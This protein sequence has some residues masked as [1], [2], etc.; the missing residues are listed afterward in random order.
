MANIN[1]G[2]DGITASENSIIVIDKL[3]R[4]PPKNIS[5]SQPVNSSNNVSVIDKIPRTPPKFVSSQPAANNVS[6][7]KSPPNRSRTKSK[8]SPKSQ[9]SKTTRSSSVVS[10][11]RDRSNSLSSTNKRKRPGNSQKD[12]TCGVCEN[13][14]EL[15]DQDSVKCDCC[16]SWYHS[17]CVN[18]SLAELKAISLLRDKVMWYCPGCKLGAENLH[19]A[20]IM[21]N[22]RIGNLEKSVSKIEKSTNNLK[23]QQNALKDDIKTV[24]TKQTEEIT[25]VEEMIETNKGYIDINSSDIQHNSARINAVKS[26]V[27]TLNLKVDNLQQNMLATLQKEIKD[28]VDKKCANPQI[29]SHAEVQL[30]NFKLQADEYVATKLK[31]LSDAK[32]PNADETTDKVISFKAQIDEY[33][34]KKVQEIRDA[35][36]PMLPPANPADNNTSDQNPIQS[37]TYYQRFSTAV[38]GEL[39]ELEE[40]KRRKN[41]L[42]IM[43]LNESRTNAEDLTKIKEL[44]NILKLDKEVIINE[45]IRLGEKRRD[46]K[47]RFIRVTLQELEVRRKI[48]AKATTLREIPSGSDFHQVYIKPNL[49]KQQN[50]HSKNLQEDL[51][52]RRLANPEKTLKISKGKIVEVKNSQQ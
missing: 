12:I 27:G 13:I 45:A 34:A 43:N 15:N 26:D 48:L 29:D 22:E 47:P 20:N 36:Y 30:V 16:L 39:N 11:D 24:K 6:K 2:D 42:L 28:E 25:K 10:T 40:I 3:S 19:R 14:F 4:T 8:S 9:V 5:L 52:A 41:Q 32:T 44:F 23:S 46:G 7:G 1:Q 21:F 51:R 49:T 50:E 17:R 38:R 31:E 18:L 35:E 37:Q 33:A